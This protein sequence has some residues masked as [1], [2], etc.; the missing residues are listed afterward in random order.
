MERLEAALAKARAARENAL[1]EA[2]S[3]PL[4]LTAE[5]NIPAPEA[6]ADT[7]DAP[8][9]WSALTSLNISPKA[10]SRNRLSALAGRQGGH[11]L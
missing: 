8:A 7:L 10:I 2:D 1:N 3:A 5:Q 9:D 6:I 11:A 4:P